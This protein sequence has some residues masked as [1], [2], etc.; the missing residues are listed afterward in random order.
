MD[1]IGLHLAER[2][3]RGARSLGRGLVHAMPG[4]L[5]GLT[6]IGIAAMIWVGG[7]IIVHG[8]EEFGLA[9]PAHLIHDAAEAA[10]HAVPA[11][12]GLVEW[13]V[14]AAGAGVAGVLIG[15]VVVAAHHAVARKHG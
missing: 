1:D 12:E 7:G 2:A 5:A 10:G 15:A 3:N 6:V 9:A 13:T 4:L 14:S 8:L 11:I